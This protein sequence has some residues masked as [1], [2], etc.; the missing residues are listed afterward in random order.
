MEVKI[1]KY[2]TAEAPEEL[3]A[4]LGPCIG[5]GAIYERILITHATSWMGR[6]FNPTNSN[7]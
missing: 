3:Y 5:I 2:K 7:S 1:L 6:F 4:Y